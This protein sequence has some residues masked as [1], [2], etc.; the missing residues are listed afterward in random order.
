MEA[1]SIQ[2]GQRVAQGALMATVERID[3]DRV[4][5]VWEAA[6]GPAR[7]E[8]R[9]ADCEPEA[10]TEAHLSLSQAEESPE[11]APEPETPAAP[12]P[13]PEADE[14]GPEVSDQPLVSEDEPA[15]SEDDAE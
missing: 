1:H 2:I 7:F 5:L 14:P 4:T 11:P 9:I 3:G 15:A 6:G 10:A 13:P 12:S 8:A